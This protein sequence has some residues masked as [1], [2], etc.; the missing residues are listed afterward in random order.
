M[1]S[2][3]YFPTEKTTTWLCL[4]SSLRYNVCNEVLSNAAETA[5]VENERT[6][7]LRVWLGPSFSVCDFFGFRLQQNALRWS[8]SKSLQPRSESGTGRFLASNCSVPKP[9][10]AVQEQ[11]THKNCSPDL[12]IKNS[13]MKWH[14]AFIEC[15]AGILNRYL[16]FLCSVQQPL[17]AWCEPWPKVWNTQEG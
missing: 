5:K 1:F 11:Q 15:G 16:G 12:S 13:H 2:A 8:G 10:L 6:K 7:C 17:Q 9:S 3:R 14:R 4:M